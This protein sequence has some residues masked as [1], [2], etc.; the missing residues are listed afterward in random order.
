MLLSKPAVDGRIGAHVIFLLAKY[1]RNKS[2]PPAPHPYAALGGVLCSRLAFDLGHGTDIQPY[3]DRE[4]YFSQFLQVDI[5]VPSPFG[6][7]F[8]CQ[9]HQAR[10]PFQE[11]TREYLVIERTGSERRPGFRM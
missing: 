5:S 11:P 6:W 1:A 9:W 2:H 7:I 8:S 3:M 10:H 4:I